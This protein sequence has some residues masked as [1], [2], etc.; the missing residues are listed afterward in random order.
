MQ[1]KLWSKNF[2]YLCV[3]NL[4]L[5]S[6]IYM[7]IPVLP[8]W[9]VQNGMNVQEAAWIT[10]LSLI[11]FFGLGPICSYLLDTYKRR[12]VCLIFTLITLLVTGVIGWVALPFIAIVGLRILQ[13]MAFGMVKMSLGSG[14]VIDLTPS[15]FRTVGNYSFNSF[16]RMAISVGP[17]LGM[18]FLMHLP[19]Q[20]AF[21]ASIALGLIAMFLILMLQIPFRAPLEPAMFSTDR[22]WLKKGSLHFFVVICCTLAMG[23]LLVLHCTIQFYAMLMVGMLCSTIISKVVF[24]EADPRAEAVTGMILLVAVFILLLIDPWE[25]IERIVAVLAG[26]GINL[27]TSRILLCLLRKAEHCER[28]SANSTYLVAWEVGLGLGI[29]FTLFVNPEHISTCLFLGLGAICTGIISYLVYH[30]TH[31][32]L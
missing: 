17:C 29:F 27:C 25:E 10:T 2:S 7:L 28:G 11:S 32:A 1:Q 16:G 8:V 23:V 14:L 4:L 15:E 24:K 19:L 30:K 18:F 26:I 6:S 13:G 3:A 12:D 9:C 5:T 20:Y 31:E 22:F 21:Y